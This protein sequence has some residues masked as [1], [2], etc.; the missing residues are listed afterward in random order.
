MLHNPNVHRLPE[1]TQAAYLQSAL[2]LLGHWA[3]SLSS[4]WDTSDERAVERVMKMVN[5]TRDAL[6]QFAK[7]EYIEV[8]ERVSDI[9]AL[10]IIERASCADGKLHL[11]T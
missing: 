5:E 9:N 3:A 8:Q 7:S 11:H 10:S 1:R 6:E 4:E 2:K